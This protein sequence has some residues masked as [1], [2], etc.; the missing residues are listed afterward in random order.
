LH[1]TRWGAIPFGEVLRDLLLEL[2]GCRRE[3]CRQAG[4]KRQAEGGTSKQG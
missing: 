2:L 4:T 3:V 1:R